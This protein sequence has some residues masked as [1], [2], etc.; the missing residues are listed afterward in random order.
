MTER[1][2]AVLTGC[3][4][5]D[6]GL[7]G[8]GRLELPSK[9]SVRIGGSTGLYSLIRDTDA[10]LAQTP[11]EVCGILDALH[12]LLRRSVYDAVRLRCCEEQRGEGV[13][14]VRALLSLL[15]RLA[16]DSSR[17]AE[18]KRVVRLLGVV[19][20]SGIS[21]A[22]FKDYM[23]FLTAPSAL[24]ISLLQTLSTMLD[25]AEKDSKAAPS[26]FFCIGGSNA[27]LYIEQN[28]ISCEKDFQLVMWFRAESFSVPSSGKHMSL[29]SRQ[30]LVSCLSNGNEGFGVF[31]EDNILRLHISDGRREPQV[32]PFEEVCSD[33]CL[34]H[35]TSLLAL[36]PNRH[37]VPL[38]SRTHQ[39]A[40][41]LI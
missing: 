36:P 2:R 30:H 15:S 28:P 39:A 9:F 10:F 27:G 40:V 1:M 4:S 24:T 16:G 14:L 19:A 17:L 35:L 20:P 32:I 3:V 41:L 21:G 8:T 13:S 31:I 18:A 22:E 5:P 37:L 7:D 26:S 6:L 25:P 23:R 34:A 33:I 12:L 11:A 38:L 29:S